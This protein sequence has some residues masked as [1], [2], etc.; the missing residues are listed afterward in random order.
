[1]SLFKSAAKLIKGALR[2]GVVPGGALIASAADS[3]RTTRRTIPGVYQSETTTQ[4]F[5]H[6]PVETG[7]HTMMAA[8]A[9]GGC[10]AGFRLNKSTYVTRGGGTSH[11]GKGLKVHPKGTVC[12]KRR[13]RNVGNARALRRAVSRVRGF[14]HLA[15]RA[16]RLVGPKRSS[17]RKQIAAPIEVVRTG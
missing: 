5:D 4:Y 6:S 17:R 9:V 1:V 15:H 12:V 7:G 14:V 8:R 2:S 13:R 3:I 16:L 11:W 10:P